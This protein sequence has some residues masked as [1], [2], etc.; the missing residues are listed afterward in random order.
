VQIGIDHRAERSGAFEPRIEVEAKLRVSERSGRCPLR[1]LMRSTGPSRSRSSGGASA[2]DNAAG[3]LVEGFGCEAEHQFQPAAFDECLQIA[4]EPAAGGSWSAV[5]PPNT[6]SSDVLRAA[7]V[8]CNARIAVGQAGKIEQ[9]VRGRV[10]AADHQHAPAGVG[11]AVRTGD[12]RDSIGDDIC[13]AIF[14]DGRRTGGAERIGR[15]PR[16]GSVDPRAG[17]LDLWT[18]AVDDGQRKR[19]VG[20]AGADDLVDAGA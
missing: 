13:E 17:V 15:R 16:A 4:A 19:P 14:T 3:V 2:D 9:C 5:P 7:H 11:G 18:G 6:R 10:S 12:V 20:A 1:R 8:R